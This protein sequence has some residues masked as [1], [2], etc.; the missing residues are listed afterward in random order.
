MSQVLKL[1]AEVVPT[2][3]PSLER[4]ERRRAGILGKKPALK[5]PLLSMASGFH[6]VNFRIFYSASTVCPSVGEKDET[7]CCAVS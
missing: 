1:K 4:A 6:F 3:E 7:R 5:V 2:S